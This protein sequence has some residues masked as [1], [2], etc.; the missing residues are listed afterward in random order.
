[1]NESCPLLFLST[2]NLKSIGSHDEKFEIISANSAENVFCH[3][4]G[5]MTARLHFT[6]LLHLITLTMEDKMNHA[7]RPKTVQLIAKVLRPWADEGVISVLEYNAILAQLK[8]FAEHGKSRPDIM[9]KLI[10]QEEAAGMLGIG[11]SNFK[12]LEKEGAFSFNRRMLGGGVR[13]KNLDV[14]DFILQDQ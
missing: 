7:I 2:G 3:N 13:Y 6:I 5:I 14:I 1:M 8:Y 10:T 9:P 11:L 12:K 4:P